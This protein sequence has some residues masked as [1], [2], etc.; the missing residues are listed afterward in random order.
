MRVIHIPCYSLSDPIPVL[1]E[2]ISELKPYSSICLLATAQHLNRI[3]DA[4]RF[5]ESKG[6]TVEVGGQILGCRRDKALALQDKVDCFL[7]IGSG[8]FHPIGLALEAGK[9]VFI[10]NPL[11]QVLDKVADEEKELWLKKRE[12]R[13][14]KAAAAKS[15]GVLVSI[16]EGQFNLGEAFKLKKRLESRGFRAYLFAGDELSPENLLPFT[17]DCW[18]NTACP[19][20]VDDEYGKPV[21][22]A[23]DLD[24]VF[25]G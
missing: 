17:V 11:S 15:F 12:K 20:L 25:G 2:Q 10:L 5:L 18:V 4:R 1:E 7:Y 22:N 13:L 9:P 16:K 24:L 23:G 6:K 19:R 14:R 8:R 21:L 3:K